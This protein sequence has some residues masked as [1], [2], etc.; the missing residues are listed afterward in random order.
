VIQVSILSKDLDGLHIVGTS[1]RRSMDG[2]TE[3][4]VGDGYKKV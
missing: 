3:D 1:G 2:C 4:C